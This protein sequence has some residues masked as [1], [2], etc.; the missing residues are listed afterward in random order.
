MNKPLGKRAY[1]HIPHLPGSR[2][3]PGD[4]HCSEGQARIATV[5]TRDRHDRVFVQEKLDGTNVAVAKIGGVLVPLIRAGYRAE[6]SPYEQ[7]HLF[8]AWFRRN[9]RRFGGLLREGERA[10]GEWLAQA[11]STRYDFSDFDADAEPFVLFDIMRGNE[12][13]TQEQILERNDES[14][15]AGG[16]A[17]EFVLPALLNFGAAYA[18]SDA[19]EQIKRVVPS[20]NSNPHNG[21]LHYGFHGALDPVEG[22]IWR[23]ERDELVEPGVSGHRK[24]RVDF[25]AKYVRPDKVDGIYLPEISGVPAVWNW[26]PE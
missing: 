19:L 18:I 24:W 1:G 21:N 4:H 12:R 9:A 8:A 11:H 25:L 5:K 15:H 17:R 6:D 22:V 13:L 10:C 26:R 3:G 7:H 16:Q 23:V 20:K 14:F 2:L